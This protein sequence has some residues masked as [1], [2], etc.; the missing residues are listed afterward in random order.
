M[1]KVFTLTAI[2]AFFMSAGPALAQQATG[3]KSAIF[4][5]NPVGQDVFSNKAK[6]R[7]FY[8]FRIT[9]VN[10]IKL[11]GYTTSKPVNFESTVP[12]IFADTNLPALPAGTPAVVPAAPPALAW[13]AIP[14]PKGPKPELTQKQLDAL[15][16]TFADKYN[17]F[18]HDY[19]NV[20]LYIAAED[21]LYKMLPDIIVPDPA[22]L[23]RNV[24]MYMLNIY[25]AD[26]EYE[27]EAK[28]KVTLSN[29]YDNYIALKQ[30]YESLNK[31]TNTSNTVLTGA[32]KDKTGSIT[33]TVDKASVLIKTDPFF[34]DQYTAATKIYDELN[35]G[36]AQ[37][38]I[39]NK[40]FK[41]ISLFRRIIQPH[42]FELFTNSSQIMDDENLETPVL[43]DEKGT[44]VKTFNPVSIRAYG[45][46]KVDFSTG[47]LVTFRGDDNYAYYYADGKIKG[48]AKQSH[49]SITNSIGALA[50][51]YRR[52]ATGA[53]VALSG[54][55]SLTT[56]GVI[57]F[58]AGGSGLF[59]EKN[60][61]ALSAGLSFVKVKVLNTG[62]LD[63][64]TDTNKYTFN[65]TET[66]IN[67][68]ALY[69]PGFFVG[70][71]YN[72][73]GTNKSAAK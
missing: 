7:S 51:W 14:K 49:N 50:H 16:N 40:A 38:K 58:Y 11:I 54:G 69:K 60:R 28:L 45:G 25:D 4:E 18:T 2:A 67:Y 73:F 37:A 15:K 10:A 12:N 43:K 29:I 6:F 55:F 21:S 65:S 20:Q 9:H 32:L 52:N 57:G 68:D 64:V 71:T 48:V 46:S 24:E 47:Y 26:H 8:K 34:L 22:G 53:S 42:A 23:Q 59:L 61:L 66:T 72:I 27:L 17:D 56:D 36:D 19:R 44:I 62:N 30:A 5:I 41:G 39:F 31:I 35:K 70:I 33:V 3:D 63:K 13:A 1:K